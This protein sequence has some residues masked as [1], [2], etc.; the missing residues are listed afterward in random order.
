MILANSVRLKVGLPAHCAARLP[1]VEFGS[2]VGFS[3][4]FTHNRYA[5]NNLHFDSYHGM[6]EVIGSIAN[7]AVFK[8]PSPAVD[9]ARFPMRESE[10]ECVQ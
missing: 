2:T 1:V 8:P 4:L 6:E 5:V 3:G 10:K 9:L 7:G